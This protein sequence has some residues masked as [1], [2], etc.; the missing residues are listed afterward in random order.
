MSH[1]KV[2]NCG[3]LVGFM[4]ERGTIDAVFI[5][6][7]LQEEYHAGE[8]KLYMCF[9]DLVKTFAEYQGCLVQGVPR[10]GQ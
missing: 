6:R 8:K 9:V 10:N 3:L 2:I 5:L 7:M 1:S 4:H